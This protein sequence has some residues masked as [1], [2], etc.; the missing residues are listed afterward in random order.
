MAPV[1]P[2]QIHPRIRLW[3]RFDPS[4]KTDLFSTAIATAAGLFL[5][6]PIP[7]PDSA[8]SQLNEMA[9]VA[10]IIVTNSNHRR[11]SD[12][13][14]E[15]F[16]VPVI[17]RGDTFPNQKPARFSSVKS[18]DLIPGDIEVI[19]IEGAVEGEI[20]LYE[21]GDAGTL[22]LGDALIN[23]EPYGFALL[24]RKYCLDEK[25]MRHSLRQLL[26]KSAERILFAHGMPIV[27]KASRRLS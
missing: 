17:A 11:A 9:P 14:S 4:L 27:A 13:F 23:L 10:G 12:E 6:D 25:E 26:P 1:E 18:G 21:S 8:L 19:A 22:I 7:L 20:A 24:P 2:H 3:Q 15:R 5:V 16:S